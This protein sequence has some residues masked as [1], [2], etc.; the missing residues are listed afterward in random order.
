MKQFFLI[1]SFWCFTGLALA[2]NDTV[3]KPKDTAAKKQGSV[4][5]KN[6]ATDSTP[7]SPVQ[8]PVQNLEPSIFSDTSNSNYLTDSLT[9]DSIRLAA[10]KAL[11]ISLPDTT[12]YEKYYEHQWLPFHKTP[13]YL[14]V[15]ERKHK[16]KDLLFYILTGLVALLA[17]IRLIFPKYFK[18]LFLLF[19][20]T[21]IRQKQ[22]REQLLQNNMASLLM[23]LLFIASAGIY[24]TLIIQYKHWVDK[25]FYEL[26]FYC[27]AI[28]FIVYLGKYLFLLFSGWVFNVPDATNA[29]TFIVFLVNKVLGVVLIPF[30]LVVTFSPLPIMQVA[31]T[32]SFGLAAL[33]FGYRYLISF[34]VIRTNL[35]VS[36]LHFFLYLCAVELLPLLLIYKL[37]LNFI[38][39]SI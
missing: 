28:L 4:N 10:L 35:K 6:L 15:P 20:Q 7:K 36:A 22:T 25:P 16:G 29:Y 14:I 27:S 33:L 1:L 23:N 37:L 26:L 11:A 30:I 2:Q 21:S 31:L 5:S 12:T 32:I 39:G 24:I 18:N 19:M 38:A 3:L 8:K 34:G 13:F 9:K 17:M